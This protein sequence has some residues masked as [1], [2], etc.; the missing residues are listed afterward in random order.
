MTQ[1]AAAS[2]KGALAALRNQ[3][4][5]GLAIGTVAFGLVAGARLAGGLERIELAM[6]DRLLDFQAGLPP[7]PD[8]VVI[9]ETEG[10]LQRF[11][12]PLSDERLAD[13]LEKL[14]AMQPALVA[15]DKYRDLPIAPGSEQLDKVLTDNGN[16]FWVAKYGAAAFDGVRPPKI[17]EGT[18]RAACADIIVDS[19][20]RVRRALV[21]IGEGERACPSLTYVMAASW[22][23]A[24]GR[25]AGF[26]PQRNHALLLGET[27]LPRIGSWD[28]PY[29][30]ADAS[31]YQI[32]LRYQRSPAVSFTLSQVFD[33]GVPAEA[34]RGKAVFFGSSATSLRDF[35][36]VPPRGGR[37]DTSLPGVMVH[38]LIFG[39]LLDTATTA[40]VVTFASL[41]FTLAAAA[42]MGLLC[43]CVLLVAAR[44]PI[45][46]AI[47]LAAVLAWL[48]VSLALA[49]ANVV[50][51]PLA[52]ALAGL[53]ATMLAAGFRAWRESRDRQELMGWFSKHVSREVAEAIWEERDQFAAGGI[54][55]PQKVRVT[56]LFADIRSYTTVSE[57]LS[58]TPMVAWLNRAIS[59]MCDAVMDNHGIVT[60]FAGDQVMAVFGVPIPRKTD[61]AVCDDAAHAID[62]GLAMGERLATLNEAFATEG[63]PPVRVRVG[64]FSGEVVQAG[65][66]SRDR[67]EFTVLGDVV[68]TASRLE[69]YT[70]ED[71]GA[72]ARVLIGGP[73]RE[74]AGE[75]FDTQPLGELKLKGKDTAVSVYRVWRRAGTQ[76]GTK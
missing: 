18:A 61:A 71:D 2:A 29:A 33:G 27:V 22:L 63:L 37:T 46:G 20:L 24:H 39:E 60:H 25:Q 32:P 72:A 51:A 38:A 45:G 73:T 1:S 15:V 62:A 41:P 55:P 31:G 35:F 42:A 56:V 43:A 75:K 50:V 47:A 23:A 53:L 13:F 74:L 14:E 16:I 4:A 21:A 34:I 49:H 26:D 66:G 12:H 28:G 17:L 10:D 5:L 36:D 68:N 76:Q 70:T 54:I 64:I 67:F 58:I 8:S 11:G 52:P 30:G 69:S 59:C 19:D 65:L 7:Q 44:V 3:L 9:Y 48:P 57:K 40:E 6:H